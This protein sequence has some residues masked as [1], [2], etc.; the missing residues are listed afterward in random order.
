ML[1]QA[2]L[3]LPEE[4]IRRLKDILARAKTI[5]EAIQEFRRFK[6]EPETMTNGNG[7]YVVVQGEGELLRRLEQGWKLVQSLNR[8]KYLLQRS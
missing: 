2:A 8:D 3:I 5:D 4:K 1:R 6:E 7:E